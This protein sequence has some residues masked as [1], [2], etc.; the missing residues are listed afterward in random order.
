MRA[1]PLALG[2]KHLQVL[3]V[4]LLA[5]AACLVARLRA[6]LH[7]LGLFVLDLDHLDQSRDKRLAV[8]QSA[9]A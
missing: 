5:K 8:K 4:L 6:S 9:H 3:F 1:H 2:R 7:A